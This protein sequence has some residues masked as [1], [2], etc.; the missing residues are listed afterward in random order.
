MTT[1]AEDI[2]AQTAGYLAALKSNSDEIARL[3]EALRTAEA[4]YNIALSDLIETR[5]ALQ[6]TEVCRAEAEKQMY[7]AEDKRDEYRSARDRAE[8][9]RAED[10]RQQ[11]ETVRALLEQREAIRAERDTARAEAEQLAKASELLLLSMRNVLG[12]EPPDRLVPAQHK[13]FDIRLLKIALAAHRAAS[14]ALETNE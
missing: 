14:V 6:N 5:L 3:A 7:A 8:K 9:A 10:Y 13:V 1:L 4:K 12:D 2:E 11:I